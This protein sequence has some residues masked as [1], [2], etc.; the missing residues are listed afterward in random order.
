MFNNLPADIQALMGKSF[1]GDKWDEIFQN[2]EIPEYFL[3]I[4]PDV[5]VGPILRSHIPK[6]SHLL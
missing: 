2:K 5:E 3:D 1:D 6:D 4:S